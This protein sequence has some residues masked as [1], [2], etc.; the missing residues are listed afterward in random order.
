VIEVRVAGAEDLPAVAALRAHDSGTTSDPAF[1][2]RLGDWLA[3]EGDRRTT[4]LATS[5]GTPAGIGSLFEYRR[6]PRPDR[7]AAAW[8]YVGN[9]VVREDLRCRGIGTALLDAI[10]AAAD[11]RGYVR[12]VLAPSPRAVGLYLRAGFVVTDE[13][14]GADRLLVRPGRGR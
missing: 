5:S 14:A 3:G 10:V 7:P 12:L 1:E 8:G 4:F 2:R 9:M 6:M 11:A 13:G